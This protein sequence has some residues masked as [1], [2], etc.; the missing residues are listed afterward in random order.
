VQDSSQPPGICSLQS[1]N[2]HIDELA[3]K[4]GFLLAQNGT[5]NFPATKALKHPVPLGKK[6]QR[7]VYRNALRRSCHS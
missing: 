5:E 1:F 7:L 6:N 2:Q 4:W 3:K